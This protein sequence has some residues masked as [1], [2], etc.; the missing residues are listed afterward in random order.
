MF[1]A[2]FQRAS[3]AADDGPSLILFQ[4]LP[5]LCATPCGSTSV[6]VL[7]YQLTL[8]TVKILYKPVSTCTGT[9]KRV[10]PS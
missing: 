6:P 5:W 8:L 9:T 4:V 3:R 1:G 7:Q 2:L 10:A